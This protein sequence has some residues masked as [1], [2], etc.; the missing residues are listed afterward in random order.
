MDLQRPYVGVG[1]VPVVGSAGTAKTGRPAAGGEE[2]TASG[3]DEDGEQVEE[4]RKRSQKQQ[5]SFVAPRLPPGKFLARQI[6]QLV[7]R[8]Q[9]ALAAPPSSAPA[10]LT[11]AQTATAK[12][13][14]DGFHTFIYP[15]TL[16]F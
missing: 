12:G 3:E 4:M 2:S 9:A 5:E 1:G 13:Y 6:R 8:K 14:S 16:F 10:S 7:T 11:P 15:C